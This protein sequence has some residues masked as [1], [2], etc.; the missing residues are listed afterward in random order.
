MAKS[1]SGRTEPSFAGRSRTWPK[2]A[3]TLKESPRYLL[4]VLALEGD[5]TTT[6]SVK[7]PF[8]SLVLKLVSIVLR[9]R[10]PAARQ[11]FNHAAKLQL[12]DNRLHGSHRQLAAP[13]QLVNIHPFRA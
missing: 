9:R 8:H 7:E 3:S 11:A 13:R 10:Y 2:E 5:S 4:I 6:I 12:Q 1:S